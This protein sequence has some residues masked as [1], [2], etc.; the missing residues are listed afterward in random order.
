MPNFHA[1]CHVLEPYEEL[2]WCN[3]LKPHYLAIGAMVPIAPPTTAMRYVS[4]G[5][6][7]SKGTG[8]YRLIID[9]RK[10]NKYFRNIKVKYETLS[11]LRYCKRTVTHAVSLDISD[12]YY[13]LEI[14]PSL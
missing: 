7:V 1:P 2:Y 12:A 13:H 6:L 8:G 14:H 9:L 5:R 3:T 4:K 10:L 11:V